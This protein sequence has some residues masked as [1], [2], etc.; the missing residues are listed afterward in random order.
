VKILLVASGKGGTGKSTTTA[1]LGKV[2]SRRCRVALLDLDVTGPNLAKMVGADD[3]CLCF[4][5]NFFYPQHVSENLQVFSPSML[6]PKGMPIA[7]TGS[8]RKEMIRE[9]LMKVA[10]Q[11]PD[12]LICDSPPG[13]GDEMVAV[14][15]YA[16]QVDGVIVVTNAKREALD[17]ARRLV[18]LL[19]TPRYQHI[20]ILGAVLN[21]EY[22]SLET[23]T[24]TQQ[25]PLFSDGL[26]AAAELEVEVLGS[27]PYKPG[28]IV[29]G[30]TE[31]DY[32]SVAEMVFARIFGEGS[33]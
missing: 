13:T 17:D 32:E 29:I 8:I 1:M 4:D 21:M 26:N 14:L 15:Q 28:G 27:I 33:A 7:W 16:P 22:M 6:L 23:E 25:I 3:G 9:L 20:P 31:A 24:G 5:A 19:R 2:L 18:T 12:I 30:L 10:W 11:Q